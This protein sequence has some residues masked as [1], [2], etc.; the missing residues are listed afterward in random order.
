VEPDDNFFDITSGK[1]SVLLKGARE[2]ILSDPP[3]LLSV[4]DVQK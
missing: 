2:A 3:R 4:Y 1:V